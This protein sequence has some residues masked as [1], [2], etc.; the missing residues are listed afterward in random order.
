MAKGSV[1]MRWAK[2][3]A[4][5]RFNLANSGMLPC[6]AEDLLLEPG[7]LRINPA[8]T[9][10]HPP[11]LEAI[12]AAYRADP[13]QV[14]TAPGCS[15]ANFLAFAALLEAGDEVLVE[16]PAY[17]PLLAALAFLGCRVRR[18]VR[19]FEDGYRVDP[20]ELRSLLAG[21]VRLVVLTNPHN[22]SAVLLPPAEVAE[23]ARLAESAGAHLLV[24][25]V[26]RDVWF[27]D[28]PPSHVHLGPHVLATSSLTK[29]YGLSGL[30]CGW[31]LCAPGVA[32]RLWRAR[33][34]MQG[35]DS[36]PSESL[37]AA[38]FRELP[39]LAG[40]ARAIVEPNRAQVR[41]FLDA[42]QEWL[43]CVMPSHAMMVF[44]HLKRED[45]SELLHDR[46][47]ARDTSIVPGKFFESPRH[48]RLG[49]AVRP[50]DL[51]EGLRRLGEGLG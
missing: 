2:E 41:S 37:A 4:A 51:A 27:E 34:F 23:I 33:D 36:A 1:Y 38:A 47:R 5:A 20:D 26:Y 11:L 43:D 28:A 42:H 21:R 50:D 8:S 19:R 40:R 46:L 12:A 6:S 35:A 39:R 24:D 32:D 14:V 29:T 3:H 48:F 13:A 7:D 25:E 18:F 16:R 15:G 31:I 45:D 17:E 9:D 22:P 30:R 49:F 10:G 44:P